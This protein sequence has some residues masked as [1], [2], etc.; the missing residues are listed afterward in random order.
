MWLPG[1]LSLAALVLKPLEEREYVRRDIYF[2]NEV[3]SGARIPAH[4]PSNFFEYFTLN[5]YESS[6]AITP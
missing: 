6:S 2:P 5:R 1:A 3:V 4:E